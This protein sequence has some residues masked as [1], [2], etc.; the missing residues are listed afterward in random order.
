MEVIL[1]KEKSKGPNK[2]TLIPHS[3]KITAMSGTWNASDII[4][5]SVQLFRRY[6]HLNIS[7]VEYLVILSLKWF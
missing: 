4:A 3:V 7:Q 1:P 6:I 2:A 5:S